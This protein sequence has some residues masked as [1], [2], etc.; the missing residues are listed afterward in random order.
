MKNRALDD[1][2]LGSP[3][4]QCSGSCLRPAALHLLR[5]ALN[6]TAATGCGRRL[7]PNNLRRIIGSSARAR[8][9]MARDDATP[10]RAGQFRHRERGSSV[11]S[12]GKA[13]PGTTAGVSRSII[14]ENRIVLTHLLSVDPGSSRAQRR[15]HITSHIAEA[16][17]AAAA[18]GAVGKIKAACPEVAAAA[19]AAIGAV[20]K[21][22]AARPEVSKLPGVISIR[23]SLGRHS[24]TTSE[25]QQSDSS[26]RQV[27]IIHTERNLRRQ[28]IRFSRTCK[29]GWNEDTMYRA[30]QI[31]ISFDIE[32]R[33][34]RLKQAKTICIARYELLR[35]CCKGQR[36]S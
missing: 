7:K 25:R 2:G 24:G 4:R 17:A 14:S 31:N 3:R 20:G 5:A 9:A 36:L 12:V 10:P 26:R 30:S 16:A 6:H 21:I 28:F 29:R 13:A 35:M 34:R 22:K 15:P 27:L 11:E 8:T 33:I 1:G 18:I 32:M 19:A 23:V